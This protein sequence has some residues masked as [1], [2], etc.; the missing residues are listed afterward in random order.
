MSGS[1]IMLNYGSRM[2]LGKK[3]PRSL[4]NLLSMREQILFSILFCPPPASLPTH[5]NADLLPLI[6]ACGSGQATF[7]GAGPM[8]GGTIC[9]LAVIRMMFFCDASRLDWVQGINWTQTQ[10]PKEGA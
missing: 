10:E 2:N 4:Q 5:P 7:S 3:L 9:S 8:R 6:A 1:D